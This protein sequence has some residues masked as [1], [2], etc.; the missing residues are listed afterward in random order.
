MTDEWVNNCVPYESYT[1]CYTD[2]FAWYTN[3][4]CI[5][6]EEKK[7]EQDH[8]DAVYDL[9]GPVYQFK[10]EAESLIGHNYRREIVK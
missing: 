8:L 4:R 2:Q 5:K 6:E 9:T 10:G 3:H 7:T 1:R